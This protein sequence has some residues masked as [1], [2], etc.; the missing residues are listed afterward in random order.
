[1]FTG[2]RHPDPFY[3]KQEFAPTDKGAVSRHQQ[4]VYNTIAPHFRLLQFLSSHFNASKLSNPDVEFVYD[5]FMHITLAA[6]GSGCPQPLA[7]EA[8]FHIIL[9]GSRILYHSTTLPGPMAWRTKDRILTA[10]LAWF[11]KAPQYACLSYLF[12]LAN[13]HRWSFGGNRHQI[14]AEVHLLS[15]IQSSL[16]LISNVGAPVEPS[17][18]SLKGKQELL[19][20]LLANEQ[21]RLN[22]WLFPLN[23]EKKHHFIPGPH[24]KGIPDVSLR[25]QFLGTSS[26]DPGRRIWLSQ[27]SMGSKS[28]NRSAPCA[29]LSISTADP[30]G[31]V[32]SAKLSAQSCR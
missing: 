23:Q 14:K 3:G 31:A 4:V 28:S 6:L 16:Q 24:S 7:R 32:A 15:D 5:R 27:N 29:T 22:V 9:L 21:Q 25:E 11:A 12:Y 17:L 13:A 8:Y 26:D 10:A 1:M 20:L 19:S 18:K 2:L 30:G